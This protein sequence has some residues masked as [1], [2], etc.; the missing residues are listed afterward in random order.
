MRED[1]PAMILDLPSGDFE[2][3]RDNTSLFTFLGAIACYDHVFVQTGDIED[4]V[5]SGTYIFSTHPAFEKMSEYMVEND[6]PMHLN[7]QEAAECDRTAWERMVAQQCTDIDG[8]PED[9]Q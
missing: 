8:V 2:A 7:L 1:E 9:W 3:R 5:M 6:Y 4:N